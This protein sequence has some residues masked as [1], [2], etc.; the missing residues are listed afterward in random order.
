[1]AGVFAVIAVAIAILRGPVLTHLERK[2][3][4][5][6]LQ[7]ENQVNN[8]NVEQRVL[9]DAIDQYD[10]A[11]RVTGHYWGS[12]G[13]DRYVHAGLVAAAA[14]QAGDADQYRYWK[15]VE[16]ADSLCYQSDDRFDGCDEAGYFYRMWLPRDRRCF[17]RLIVDPAK[18]R[19][20]VAPD[21]SG[22]PQYSGF[23]QCPAKIFDKVAAI[24]ENWSY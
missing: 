9:Q 18:G 16:Y 10:I 6:M 4:E 15:T 3:R 13:V 2:E 1:M 11:K 19:L 12:K 17:V 20:V 24:L 23:D 22:I 14:L 7:Q 21:Q 5:A 8:L